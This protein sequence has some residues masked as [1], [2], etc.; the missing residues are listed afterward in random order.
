[1]GPGLE[2]FFMVIQAAVAGLGVA[3]L[4]SYLIEDELRKGTL[5][6]PFPARVAGPGAYY[7]V[8]SVARSELSRVKILRKWLLAQVERGAALS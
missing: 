6:T 2:H 1:M 4:P 8:T 5:V 7:P 3:L